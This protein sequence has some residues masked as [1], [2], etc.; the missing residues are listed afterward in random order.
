MNWP[1]AYA[2]GLIGA[3]TFLGLAALRWACH[4]LMDAWAAR[5]ARQEI[6]A[7]QR[8]HRRGAAR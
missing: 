3:A 1:D 4:R 6:E 7:W 8:R 5:R 2:A